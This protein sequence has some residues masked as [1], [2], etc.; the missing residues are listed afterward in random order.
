MIKKRFSY[1]KPSPQAV[2]KLTMLREAFS[3]FDDE[4]EAIAPEASREKALYATNLEQAA[5][6]INKHVTHNDPASVQDTDDVKLR[7]TTVIG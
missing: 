6:W 2:E 7:D 4:C 1:H 3:R 5:L